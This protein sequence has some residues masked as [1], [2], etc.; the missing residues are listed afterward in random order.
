MGTG[1][2]GRHNEEAGRDYYTSKEAAVILGVSPESVRNWIRE[3]TLK[4]EVYLN[5]ALERR[6]RADKNSVAALAKERGRPVSRSEV[7]TVT[8]RGISEIIESLTEVRRASDEKIMDLMG[9]TQNS[10][11][12]Q[13]QTLV[14]IHR[15]VKRSN[16]IREDYNQRFFHQSAGTRKMVWVVLITGCILVVITLINLVFCI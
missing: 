7:E 4:G 13:S 11:H 5:E 2:R 3:G 15:E 14:E 10:V 16:D 6:Y 1:T 12:A 9:S 8:D